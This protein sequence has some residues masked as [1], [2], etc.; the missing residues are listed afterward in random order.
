MHTFPF[1]NFSL[2]LCGCDILPA[3]VCAYVYALPAEA[4][5]GWWVLWRYRQLWATTWMLRLEHRASGRAASI[6]NHWAL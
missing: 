6:L 1:L 5:R 3:C 4:R 2:I